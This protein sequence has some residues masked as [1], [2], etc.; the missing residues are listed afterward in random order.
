VRGGNEL[1]V[2]SIAEQS[3]DAGEEQGVRVLNPGDKYF[4]VSESDEVLTADEMESL[5]KNT[6]RLFNYGTVKYLDIFGQEH[7]YTYR[8]E[9]GSGATVAIRTFAIS[10]DGNTST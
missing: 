2:L 10:A 6:H 8:L 7:T 9:Y 1:K 3:F 4:T 5:T